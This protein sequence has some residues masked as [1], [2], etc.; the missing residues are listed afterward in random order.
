MLRMI[1]T[2][3]DQQAWLAR[4][5]QEKGLAPT[6]L[7]QLARLAPTTLT[8][9]L[10][11]PEH[12]TALSHRTVA[13]IEQA[14]GIRFS[15][16]PA[17]PPGGF[18]DRE[19]EPYVAQP[20]D[21]LEDSIR[22]LV[23][24]RNAIDPWRLQSKALDGAGFLPGDV[25]LVDMNGTPQPGDVVCAQVYDWTKGR[26]ETIFRIYELPF[27]VSSSSDPALRRPFMVDHERVIVRGVVE[28]MIRP[29]VARL[30]A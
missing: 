10:N 9:F 24:G 17:P 2:R 19:S 11:N 27:L 20:G 1:D 23:A 29:R 13:A 5:L 16:E 15:S 12:S 26:A 21:L 18:R 7:A 3:A 25:L 28:A 6:A 22:S 14:T 4:V 30:A 8:R